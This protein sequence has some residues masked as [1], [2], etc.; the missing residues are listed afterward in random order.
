MDGICQCQ[1][2]RTSLND[3]YTWINDIRSTIRLKCNGIGLYRSVGDTQWN[4]IV[5]QTTDA[6]LSVTKCKHYFIVAFG[7]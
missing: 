7:I 5:T 3:A 6:E 4:R 2:L 1:E